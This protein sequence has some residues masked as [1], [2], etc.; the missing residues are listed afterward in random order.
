MIGTR[1]H[2]QAQLAA[3]M[4]KLRLLCDRAAP[5]ATAGMLMELHGK[6]SDVAGF[7]DEMP[8]VDFARV[9]ADLVPVGHV[10]QIVELYKRETCLGCGVQLG[11]GAGGRGLGAFCCIT[12]CDAADCTASEAATCP[13]KAVQP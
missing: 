6:L 1:A 5:P 9:A 13:H 10:L 4:R 3:V 11:A 12:C 7:L 8:D 2:S